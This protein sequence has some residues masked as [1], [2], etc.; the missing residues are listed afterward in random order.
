MRRLTDPASALKTLHWGRNYLYV[1]RL[2][3]A[4][5]PVEVVVKQF[6]HRSS[7][8]RLR[9]RLRGSKA[10]KSWRVAWTL[11]E[12]GLLTPEPVMW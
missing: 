8:E 4:G 6:R 10:R 11:L 3:T 2:D 12:A 1:A 7:R 5:G 9:R